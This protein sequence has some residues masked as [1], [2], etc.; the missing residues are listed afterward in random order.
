[1]KTNSSSTVE[2]EEAIPEGATPAVEPSPRVL[3]L[4]VVQGPATGLVVQ[5]DPSNPSHRSVTIGRSGKCD[6]VLNDEEVSTQH[7]RI[8]YDLTTGVWLL[9]DLGSLNGTSLNNKSI[10]RPGRIPGNLEPLTSHHDQRHGDDLFMDQVCFAY[11]SHATCTLMSSQSS[12]T[13]NQNHGNEGGDG[14]LRRDPR[15][16]FL[17]KASHHPT[18]VIQLSAQG[19]DQEEDEVGETGTPIGGGGGLREDH[20]HDDDNNHDD[21]RYKS[22]HVASEDPR[23]VDDEDSPSHGSLNVTLQAQSIVIGSAR[24]DATV[25]VI[26]DRTSQGG[27]LLGRGPMLTRGG[28]AAASCTA[29]GLTCACASR[30]GVSHVRAGTACEDA[31]FVRVPVASEPAPLAAVVGIFDGHCGTHASYLACTYVGERIG[32]LLLAEGSADGD[33]HHHHH[34]RHHDD[35]DG[36]DDDGVIKSALLRVFED[37]DQKIQEACDAGCTATVVVIWPSADGT[38]INLQCANVGD[39]S[40]IWIPWPTDNPQDYHCP[41]DRVD[42]DEGSETQYLKELAEDAWQQTV[43]LTSTHRVDQPDEMARIQ[44][45]GITLLEGQTRLYGLQL[46]RMLGDR[47]FKEECD[48]FIADPHVSSV[49]RVNQAQGGI[50]LMATDGLWD[51][52]SPRD[53]VT[54]LLKTLRKETTVTATESL[55]RARDE[56][57]QAARQGRGKDDISLFVARIRPPVIRGGGGS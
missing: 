51:E 15:R 38:A 10:T 53:A 1:M 19:D 18:K 8:T 36:G 26:P 9:Q 37:T 35:D 25:D 52:I 57:L 50:L 48:A 45:R 41:V 5:L 29:L 40:A 49:V 21:D 31:M 34:H 11:R 20:G 33:H 28:G 42:D 13:G 6:I 17:R 2:Q 3:V 22:L 27:P 44:A 56:L 30:V 46:A 14:G 32:E 54:I 47:I 23:G 39:S 12:V 24:L 7:A 43:E 16:Q 55:T 4:R